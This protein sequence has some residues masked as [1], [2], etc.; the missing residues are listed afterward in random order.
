MSAPATMHRVYR[1][2]NDHI[3]VFTSV[4]G[5]QVRYQF[6]GL[7]EKMV[8]THNYKPNW[9]DEVALARGD[10]ILV[11]SKHE[12]ERWF[13]RLQDGRRGYFPA[14]CVMEIGQDCLAE[15]EASK[16]LSLRSSIWAH[17][18]SL[19]SRCG[20][21]HGLQKASGGEGA[22]RGG[23]G[24]GGGAGAP[25]DRVGPFL[26]LGPQVPPAPRPTETPRSPGLLHRMLS[27]RWKKTEYQ[28]AT[29]RAFEAD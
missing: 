27:K 13:G 8:A 22:E 23:G 10:V 26:V 29:N 21:T 18:L 24:G 28:G 11:M 3:E 25:R 9:P 19:R 4:C 6:R 14:S 2:N 20:S 7:A 15:K 5:P 12:E 1:H 17:V 16:A